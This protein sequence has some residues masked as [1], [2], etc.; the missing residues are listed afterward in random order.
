[1]D[2][3]LKTENLGVGYGRRTIL[4]NINLEV[5]PG[6]LTALIGANG[7]GKSTLLRTLSGAQA[8]TAG[9]VSIGGT[10][11]CGLGKQKLARRLAMVF[12]DRT[13]AG[14]LTVR[15]TVEIG[16]HPYTG[17]FGRLGP[18]DKEA[19]AEALAS[20]GM[21]TYA[22]RLLGTLSD[23][24]RQKVMLAR[25]LAQDTPLIILDEP[26]AFLD[27]AGRLE[28]NRLLRQLADK[29]RSIILSTHDIASSVDAADTLWIVDCENRHVHSAAKHTA[30]QSGL[31]DRAFPAL[32][33][34]ASTLSFKQ[35]V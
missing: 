34:D 11:L 15:E 1:M 8:P 20:V 24:E 7:S 2:A 16:R 14:A 28:I 22:D 12:T 30:I 35:S 31:L 9:T 4:H 29:G 27:V 23:G 21:E 13:G 32:R 25:A 10:A 3:I 33:F 5:A 18:K 17:P 26:T 6:S 19:V